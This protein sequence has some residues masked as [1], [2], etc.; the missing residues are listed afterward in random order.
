MIVEGE[1][2][3]IETWLAPYDGFWTSN[4]PMIGDWTSNHVT[5]SVEPKFTIPKSRFD[6]FGRT[7]AK[8]L[9]GLRWGQA[10]HQFMDL[11]KMTS[12]K[13]WCDKLY[14]A[15]VLKAKAMVLEVLDYAH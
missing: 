14:N 7:K 3:A 1:P 8:N 4:N 6:E 9:N 13:E 5:K 12:Q 11:E 15:P 2:T 10:F